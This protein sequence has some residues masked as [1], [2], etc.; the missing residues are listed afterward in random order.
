MFIYLYVCICLFVIYIFLLLLVV[1]VVLILYRSCLFF[2]ICFHAPRE[3]Q[4][5]PAAMESQ[6]PHEAA[7]LRHELSLVPSAVCSRRLHRVHQREIRRGPY[8]CSVATFLQV[9]IGVQ[10][11]YLTGGPYDRCR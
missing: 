5:L 7:V 10:R 2:C 4:D 1:V 6:L 9:G 8:R 3:P 11:W